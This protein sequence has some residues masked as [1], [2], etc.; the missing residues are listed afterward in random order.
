MQESS[1]KELPKTHDAVAVE[2]YWLKNGACRDAINRVS[3]VDPAGGKESGVEPPHSRSSDAIPYVILM[4]PPNITGTL[5]NGH[6][7]FVTLQDILIRFHRMRGYKTLWLPGL[8][9]A[10]IATQAVVERALRVEEGKSR[11]DVGRA[12]FLKRVWAWKERNGNRIIEQLKALGASADWDRLVFTMDPNHCKAVNE[13][14]ARLWNDGLIYRGRRLVNWDPKTGTAVSDEE[15]EHVTRKGELVYFAYPLRGLAACHPCIPSCHPCVSSCHP[16]ESR[17]PEMDS[18]FRG[19]DKMEGGN[20]KVE[21]GNDSSSVTPAP[22]S[23]GVNSAGVH[24]ESHSARRACEE[25]IVATTR[26]ETMLGDVAVAVHPQDERYKH[27]VGATLRHPFFPDRELRVIADAMVKPE[28]G[29]GAVKI[30]PAHDPNDFAVGQRHGLPC[31]SVLTSDGRINDEGGPYRGLPKQEARR[32]IEEDL[33]KLGLFRKKEPIEHNVSVSQRSGE[34]IEP[35]ISRQYFVRTESMARK[36]RE[37]VDSGETQIFPSSW[38][39]TWNHFLCNIQDWCVSRQL[40]WGHR[41]PVYYDL[42]KLRDAIQNDAR[43]RG[44]E[45]TA[46]RAL[47]TGVPRRELLRIALDTLEDEWIRAFSVASVEDLT[48]EQADRYVQEEDVLDTWFS[49]GLWPLAT[50]GWPNKTADLQTFYPSAVLETGFDI[51]FF[52]VARMVMLGTH[53]MG[54]SPFAHVYLHAMVRDAHGRKMSKS[55]GNAV[56]P[57]D[58]MRGATLKQLQDKAR[59][60]PMAADRLPQVLAGIAKQFPEGIPAAG[61]DGLRLS[62]AIL[63]GQGR[64]VRLAVPRITGYRAFLNKL[65]NATRFALPRL[66]QSSLVPLQQLRKELS[67]PDRWILS[68]LQRTIRT[69]HESLAVYRFDA[70]AQAVYHFVWSQ[71]CD[72]Y[73]ECVKCDGL[74]P[75]CRDAINRVST[76]VLWHVLETS[77]RLLHPFCPFITEELWRV[78]RP[79]SPQKLSHRFC[80]TSPYPEFDAAWVD[81]AAES[82]MELLQQAVTGIRAARAESGLPPSRKLP[83]ILLVDD[84][85]PRGLFA[86]HASLVASLA[87]AASV[88]VRAR[89]GFAAPKGAVVHPGT[90]VHAMIVRGEADVQA[91]RRTVKQQLEKA[92]K[93]LATVA[94]VLAGAAF[95]QR[96]PAAVVQAKREQRVALEKKVGALEQALQGL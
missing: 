71:L 24:K 28:F 87:R 43:Q 95:A 45:T 20:D 42:H 69:V 74:S 80:C 14:F 50:L 94:A 44:K 60:H 41:I 35:M 23:A 82:D 64:D 19:N 40:W 34:P 21:G 46:L 72:W 51:L 18:R 16:C 86:S 29:S 89:E 1:G 9:H 62:L 79:L 6:A 17:G 75:D 56:D 81:E 66:Q 26:L 67:L 83:V 15:V 10:G 22:A 91:R 78:L 58:V 2:R 48:A 63:S 85:A 27:L 3:V 96:A 30:T 65:W 88:D 77:V 7:L 93:E 52:W 90:V 76:S 33:R 73:V 11:R 12:E 54:R 61:A 49:S 37:V 5:H 92:R 47:Q 25:I 32:R 84:A 39:K 70:A 8:D 31:L 59:Q 13:A 57:L 68:C 4:P 53:F 38:K 55:L 36:A